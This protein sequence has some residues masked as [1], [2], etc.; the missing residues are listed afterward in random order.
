MVQRRARQRASTQ[1]RL[2]LNDEAGK[3]STTVPGQYEYDIVS[4]DAASSYDHAELYAEDDGCKPGRGRYDAGRRGHG[5]GGTEK[6]AGETVV[7]GEISV[8][9]N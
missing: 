6:R 4:G 5:G 8:S 2:Q 9:E 7:V 3:L 1:R